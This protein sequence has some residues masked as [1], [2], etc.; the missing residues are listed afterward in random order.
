MNKVTSWTARLLAVFLLAALCI[1]GLPLLGEPA[2]AAA[3]RD[4]Q[5]G[6][7][8]H[9]ATQSKV[10]FAIN[11][12]TGSPYH[13]WEGGEPA[14]RFAFNMSNPLTPSD[15]N[16]NVAVYC[17][18]MC[19]RIY[20]PYYAVTAPEKSTFWNSLSQSAREGI[21]LAAGLGWPANSSAAL[22]APTD[23]DARAATQ[24]LIWEFQKGFRTT[25][26]DTP[27]VSLEIYNNVKGT[28]AEA[29]Y[30]KILA[31]A[32]EYTSLPGYS[33]AKLQ[34]DSR[35][36]V[37]CRDGQQTMFCYAHP[38]EPILGDGTIEIYKT[39]SDGKRLAGAEFS[40]YDAAN[41]RVEQ[42]TTDSNGYG[43][44]GS[45]P[46]GTYTIVETRFPEGFGLRTDTTEW[47][48]TLNEN[49]PNGT[50]TIHAVNSPALGKAKI[51]KALAN[52]EAGSLA[53]WSFTV[54]NASGSEV[55]T[56]TTNA[57]GEILLELEPGTY[58]V[59]ENIPEDSLWEC[60]EGVTQTVTVKS[61]E[62]AAVTFTN[63]LRP[64][65]IHIQKVDT[66]GEPLEG[67]E[68]LL[69]WSEDGSTWQ[70]VTYT[71]S[72]VP[73]I[74]GCTTEGLTDGRLVSDQ[75]GL[76]TFSGLYPTLQ[77]RL[78]ETATQDG[79]QLLTEPAY[80]GKL[81]VDKD[82]R[83][84]LKVVNAEIFTLPQTGTKSMELLP[85]GVFLCLGICV[86]AIVSLK[87]KEA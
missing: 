18:E 87:R 61:G 25:L 86:G 69:E 24:A 22:G 63:A 78:T 20:D 50:A 75:D 47:T 38:G 41:K 30:K 21:L 73:Q 80:E 53:G 49:T 62:T 16:P 85:L 36:T 64:G 4:P 45:L 31:L 33:L 52:P 1:G 56:Y 58:T 84:S 29:A 37:L 43:I 13:L 59:T 26:A 19:G 72:A 17:I 65:E 40:I 77:Y 11:S 5:D 57:S 34:A 35:F 15:Y 28:P 68:F 10:G 9:V 39:G 51:V 7:H 60:P 8:V 67:V 3:Y 54:T 44:S 14:T 23:D 27:N 66:K 81:S 79:Y 48:V 46:Y 42:I 32:R 70:P 76:V 55:G 74:G 6:D 71:E 2:F 12:A 82:L 83:I